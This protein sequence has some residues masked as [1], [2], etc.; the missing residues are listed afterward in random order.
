MLTICAWIVFIM[1]LYKAEEARRRS[2]VKHRGG[3]D[4][5]SVELDCM[6]HG[7]LK[8][9]LIKCRVCG[10]PIWQI[11]WWCICWQVTFALKLSH[12]WATSCHSLLFCLKKCPPFLLIRD[13]WL[14]EQQ[15][16]HVGLVEGETHCKVWKMVGWTDP[17]KFN[18]WHLQIFTYSIV[19][20]Q[21][22]YWELRVKTTTLMN[23]W[24]YSIVKLLKSH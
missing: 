11:R 23:K 24:L 1:T 16:N 2:V 3:T 12:R 7:R 10:L 18:A 14:S 15:L 8:F 22:L 13:M 20:L 4:D 6:W 21:C 17:F 19:E 5:F 9:I